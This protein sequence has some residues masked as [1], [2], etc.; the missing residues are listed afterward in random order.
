[1]ANL[2]DIR[3]RIKSVKNT[4][5]ITK[6]MQLVAASK[7]K[8]AQDQAM[9]G[10][11][12]ADLLNKVLVN[13]KE[14]TSEAD[15]PLLQEHEG[16]RELVVL[17]TTDKG[18]CGGLNTNLIRLVSEKEEG[19][20]TFVTIGSK[21]RQHL[22]RVKKDL[23]ADFT[24]DDPVAFAETKQVSEFIM[25]KFLSGEYARVKVGFTNFINTMSQ[26]PMF[27]TLLPIRPIDLGRDSSF[28]GVGREPDPVDVNPGPEYGGYIF[29]PSASAVLESVVPQYVNYQLYQMV[30]ESRASEHS[31]RMVAMK[32]ATDNAED[33]IKDLT[34]VYNKQRQAA[35]TSELLE[36]TTAM[37]ALE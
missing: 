36:I 29:E 8:K 35:I 33:M 18:L 28:V 10:R 11:P 21:G 19:N 3:R 22:A 34:L 23:L 7:M 15:H 25:E 16:D 1:M 12:Y 20:T 9:S 31:A 24:V 2:R 26:E 17:V 37:R 5:Q 13:L 30:L 27:E 4:A 14:Q 32:A 6:A